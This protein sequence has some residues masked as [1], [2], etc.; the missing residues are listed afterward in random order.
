MQET[1]HSLSHMHNNVQYILAAV[2]YALTHFPEL[3][4]STFALISGV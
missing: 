4:I 1:Y 2:V 3:I